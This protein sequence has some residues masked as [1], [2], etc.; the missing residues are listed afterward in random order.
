MIHAELT[1][2]LVE[3]TPHNNTNCPIRGHASNMG[4]RL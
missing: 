1:C 2:D 3:A 4:L